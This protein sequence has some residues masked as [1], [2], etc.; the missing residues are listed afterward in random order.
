MPARDLQ[1]TVGMTAG[2]TQCQPLYSKVRTIVNVAHVA[3]E[4]FMHT[5]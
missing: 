1:E 3:N 5:H 4:G 2:L